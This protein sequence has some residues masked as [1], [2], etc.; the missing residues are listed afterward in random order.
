MANETMTL[1]STINATG[2]SAIM[3]FDAI[4]Q[5]FTD[6]LVLF[7]GRNAASSNYSGITIYPNDD[8]AG[9]KDYRFLT[10]VG[11]SV[12][13]TSATNNLGWNI[14][15]SL[16]GNNATSN[17]FASMQFYIPNYT[18]A[19]NKSMSVDTVVENN[20]SSAYDLGIQAHIWRNTAAITKLNM[21][22]PNN[23]ATGTTASLYGILKGSGGATVS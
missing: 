2:S 6:L 8:T 14:D 19:T 10:G 5:T 1:I 12:L 15:F 4:P 18:S 3:I 20:S 22:S 7:S 23:F 17:T 13:S 9:T 16:T 21:Q 11:T